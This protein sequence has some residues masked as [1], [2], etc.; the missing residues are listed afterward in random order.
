M[1]YTENYHLPQ[2]EE[3]DRV[4]RTD[5]NRMCADMDAGLTKNAADAAAA[6]AKVQADAAAA[7]AAAKQE[8]A[9]KIAKAQSTA[10][11]AVSKADAAQAT[12]DNAYC[13]GKYPYKVGTYVGTGELGVRRFVEVGFTPRFVLVTSTISSSV[14]MQAMGGEGNTDHHPVL[15]ADNGFT[16]V[17]HSG[18]PELNERYITYAYIAFL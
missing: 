15:P 2:W 16:V 13:P 12:A 6:T 17:Q 11:T 5:F 3:T 7:T 9:A 14:T 8:N 4:L 10:D 1:N 18:W